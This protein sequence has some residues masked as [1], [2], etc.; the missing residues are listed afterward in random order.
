VQ[1]IEARAIFL[2]P[3][4]GVPRPTQGWRL[5]SI[6]YMPTTAR[7]SPFG[8]NPDLG[9]SRLLPGPFP[10]ARMAVISRLIEQP[11]GH[12]TFPR[13]PTVHRVVCFAVVHDPGFPSTSNRQ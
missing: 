13:L 8:R 1:R 10:G 12:E 2:S 11:V 9:L 5:G 3:R 6:E 7:S 4:I